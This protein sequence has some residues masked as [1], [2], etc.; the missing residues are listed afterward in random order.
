MRAVSSSTIGAT[1]TGMAL[2]TRFDWPE[3]MRAISART[4]RSGHSP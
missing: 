1:S 4:R 3:R 2:D